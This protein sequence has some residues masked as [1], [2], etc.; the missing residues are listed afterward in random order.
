VAVHVA[1]QAKKELGVAQGARI[2]IPKFFFLFQPTLTTIVHRIH[3][4]KKKKFYKLH[5][6]GIEPGASRNCPVMD[7][8]G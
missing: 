8:N 3:D 6:P 7:G 4:P 1:Q 5:R 2:R